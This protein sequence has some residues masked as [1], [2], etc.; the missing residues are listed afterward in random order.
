MS[1]DGARETAI[2]VAAALA[3]FL[4]W[5]LSPLYFKAI[6][7]VPVV[8][9]LAHRVLWT[10]VL[11]VPVTLAV[12]RWGEAMA[13]LRRPRRLGVYAVTTLLVSVNWTLFIYAVLVGRVLEVSLGYF[14]NP[15]VNVLFGLLFLGERLSRLQGLAVALAALGVAVLV[16]A[17]GQFPWIALSLAVTFALYTLVRKKNAIDPQVG[18]LVETALLLPLALAAV[19]W[20]GAAG[21]GHFGAGW[22]DSALLIA[23]GVVTGLPLVLV[24]H[25]AKRLTLSTVGLMQYVAP[26]LQFLLAVLV[27][28]EAF[29][30]AHAVTFALI[31]IGLALFSGDGWL[32][33]RRQSSRPT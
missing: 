20:L 29:T 9:I 2:G 11:M 4:W 7:H 26:S 6:Q 12:G 32:R 23:A 17:Y 19:V 25:G 28:R 16:A 27:F 15:L 30:T 33:Y 13:L 18:L 14:I 5:G 31:W 21:L 24:M 1:G 10:C 3:A 8:E 22:T